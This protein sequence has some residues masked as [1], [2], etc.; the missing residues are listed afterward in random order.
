MADAMTSSHNN[1]VSMFFNPAGLSRQ[2]EFLDVNF[3]S[4]NW[5]AGI[6]HD[7]MS[8]SFSPKL[9]NM[10]VLGFLFLMLTMVNYKAR[11]YG[12][13]IRDLLIRILFTISIGS[14]CRIWEG[15][16]K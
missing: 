2:V 6:K 11:W 1:S 12:T 8:F 15:T 5:I 7:A 3:S 16:I 13:M 14:R 10:A 4:N 9:V